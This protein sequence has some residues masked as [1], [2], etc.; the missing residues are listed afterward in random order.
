MKA[1]KHSI[2]LVYTPKIFSPINL[3]KCALITQFFLK[4]SQKILISKT[5][6]S[7]EVRLMERNGTALQKLYF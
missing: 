4:F 6:E 1:N 2:F 5:N 3:P 7:A